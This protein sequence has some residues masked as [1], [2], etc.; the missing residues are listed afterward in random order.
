MTVSRRDCDVRKNASRLSRDRDVRDRDYNPDSM[1]N[2]GRK[3]RDSA[4]VTMDSVQK[5]TIASLFSVVQLN[6]IHFIFGYRVGFSGLADQMALFS[7]QFYQ[8]K[9][10]DFYQRLLPA[11]SV[12]MIIGYTIFNVENV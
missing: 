4:M 9:D 3:I 10:G 2:C 12:S 6:L 5:T 8:T 7:V 1:A 11:P